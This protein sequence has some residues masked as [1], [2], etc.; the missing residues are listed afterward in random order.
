MFCPIAIPR[1]A[2]LLSLSL[3]IT[4]HPPSTRLDV[5]G[6]HRPLPDSDGK[7]R[8]CPGRSVGQSAVPRVF[9][10]AHGFRAAAGAWWWGSRRSSSYQPCKQIQHRLSPVERTVKD[11]HIC[12]AEFWICKATRKH[13]IGFSHFNSRMRSTRSLSSRLGYARVPRRSGD[14][15]STAVR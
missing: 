13:R 1:Y 5:V 14:G 11:P 2:F 15:Q 8:K 6:Q 12:L 3:H 4:K 9:R 10:C 7:V